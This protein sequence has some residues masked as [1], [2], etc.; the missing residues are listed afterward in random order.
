MLNKSNDVR[1]RLGYNDIVSVAKGN[2]LKDAPIH[3]NGMKDQW[4]VVMIDELFNENLFLSGKNS[5][6]N[7]ARESPEDRSRS[8]CE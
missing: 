4:I 2:D 5:Q 1:N 8:W 6:Q 7:A 3:Q